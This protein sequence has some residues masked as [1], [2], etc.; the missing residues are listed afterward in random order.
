MDRK[1]PG[2]YTTRLIG[3]TPLLIRIRPAASIERQSDASITMQHTPYVTHDEFMSGY[4]QKRSVLLKWMG[5]ITF[6]AA[7]ATL[8]VYFTRV[9]LEKADKLSSAIGVFIALIALAVTL[10]QVATSRRM[11]TTPASDEAV[12]SPASDAVLNTIGGDVDHSP[13]IQARNIDFAPSRSASKASPAPSEAPY[14]P[15]EVRNEIN[16]R[17]SRSFVI[18]G[19][20]INGADFA[21]PPTV[22]RAPSDG[23]NPDDE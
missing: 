12:P 11:A 20:D 23:R 1:S 15:G 21:V 5:G 18:Q 7:A 3:R 9:G 2:H 4:V 13:V 14:L 8:A 6:A 22:P 10:Y 17:V 16:C 19:R